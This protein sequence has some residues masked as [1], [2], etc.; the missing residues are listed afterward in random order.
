MED[1]RVDLDVYNGPLDLLLYLIRKDEVEPEEISVARVTEQYLSYIHTL[2]Q[3]DINVAAEF[4]V[5][6]ATLMELKS[7]MIVPREVETSDDGESN[8][9][10]E[11]RF[12]LIQ[13]LLAYKRFKD[14]AEDLDYRRVQ[15]QGQYARQ[16]A[17]IKEDKKTPFVEVDDVDIW[18]LLE[19][20]GRVL[21]Q[22]GAPPAVHEVVDDDTPI[23]THQENLLESLREK[24]NLALLDVFKDRRR[25]EILGLFLATLELARQQFIRVTQDEGTGDIQL[26]LKTDEERAL[27]PD[28]ATEREPADPKNADDFEWPDEETRKTYVSRQQR[29]WSGESIEEDEQFREDLEAMDSEDDDWLNEDDEDEGEASDQGEEDEEVG[30][31]DAGEGDDAEDEGDEDEDDDDE[32]EEDGGEDEDD[33]E[34]G[35]DG[36]VDDDA[37]EADEDGIYWDDEDDDD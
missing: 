30:K 33:E 1:Y 23:E 6:A 16:P 29:R 35:E 15:F 19:A 3:L 12:E 25:G 2:K 11:Q 18:D 7:A 20:Y 21:E 17:V 8:D 36:G 4:L 10:M 22:V 31:E 32:E 28:N 9:P 37:V 34:D 24:G 27:T 14:A 5:M 26:V 13:Q